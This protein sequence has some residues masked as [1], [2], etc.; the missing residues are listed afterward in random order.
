MTRTP[1][2]FSPGPANHKKTSRHT[3][4][5]PLALDFSKRYRIFLTRP[6]GE[7][8]GVPSDRIKLVADDHDIVIPSDDKPCHVLS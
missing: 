2:H 8:M 3:T 7:H 6:R 1:P 5:A 4:L